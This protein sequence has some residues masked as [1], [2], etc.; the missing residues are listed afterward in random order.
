MRKNELADVG[1]AEGV[2]GENA[3]FVTEPPDYFGSSKKKKVGLA[4]G[5]GLRLTP[6]CV[7]HRLPHKDG[8]NNNV[9]NPLA[10][11]FMEKIKDGIL[12]TESGGLADKVLKAGSHMWGTTHRN[13]V[14]V[15]NIVLN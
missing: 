3:A 10:K 13:S 7:F 12:A 6:H 2:A 4:S 9:G 15:V 8:K 14:Y 11:D 1:L 5:E